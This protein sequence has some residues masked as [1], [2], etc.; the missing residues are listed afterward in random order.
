RAALPE[1][2]AALGVDRVHVAAVVADVE[3]AAVVGRR[4]LHRAAQLGRPADLAAAGADRGEVA[5]FAAGGDGA[6]GHHRRGLGPTGQR[7]FPDHLAGAGV[8]LDDVA[9]D[10]IDDVEAVARVGRR[11]SVETADPPFPEDVPVLG[12]EREGVAGVVDRVESTVDV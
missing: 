5:G 10:E 1:Q 2:L 6:T 12:V 7:A 3:A 8:H 4:R 9:G 11:G